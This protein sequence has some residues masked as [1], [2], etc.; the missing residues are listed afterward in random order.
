MSTRR[1]ALLAL[2]L[3]CPLTASAQDV[4]E[5]FFAAARKGDAAVVKALLDKGVDVNA[6]TRYG[7][8]ALSYAC[9]KG[10][11]EV[12]KLLIE[13]GA[14]VNAKDTFYGEAPLG[15]ALSKGHAAIVKLLLDKGAAGIERALIEGVQGGNVEIVRVVLEKGGVKQEILNN[16]QLR[17]SS[18]GNKEIIDLLKKA[19]AVV[20]EVSVD[21]EILKSYAGLYKNEQVGELTVEVKDGKLRGK[22]VGQDWFTTSAQ[23]KNTFSI[24][25]VEATIT[26]D[27]EVDKVTGFTLKQSGATFVFKRVEPK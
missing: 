24:I 18:S 23:N 8:T 25:E 1:M 21:P 26:F 19:G 16:A 17:A 9:D 4:N 5:E 7:A 3:L 14:D 10:H 11:L 15:W 2:V 22:L 12:A 13:R 6:K 20:A 27:S